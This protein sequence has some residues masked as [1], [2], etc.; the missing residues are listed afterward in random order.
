MRGIVQHFSF[1]LGGQKY[2]WDVIEADISEYFIIGTD[3]LMSVKCKIDLEGN[4]LELGNGDNV[5]ATMKKN[6]DG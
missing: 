5:Q 3:F 1:Q 4:V 6:E 2:F